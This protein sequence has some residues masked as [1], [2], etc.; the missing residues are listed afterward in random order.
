MKKL[1]FNLLFLPTIF[2]FSLNL[3][4]QFVQAKSG[5]FIVTEQNKTYTLLHIHSMTANEILLEE[6]SIPTHLVTHQDWKAWMKK[7][8]LGHT[9]WILYAF[10]LSK[11]K[12]TEC[13]SFTRRAHLSPNNINLFLN[14]LLELNLVFLPDKER[15]QT[16]P[17]AFPGNVGSSKPWGP[18]MIRDGQKVKEASYN[19]YTT[20][21]PQDQ[22][23]LSGKKIV[24]YFD[25]DHK[26]FPFPY[27]IQA[28]EGG[29]KYKIRAVDSGR[30]LRSPNKSL[31]R[32]IPSF[33]GSMIK[34]ENKVYFT[35]NAPV[36]YH[37]L[38]LYAIDLSN[39]PHLTLFVPSVMNR[40]N[41]RVILEVEQLQLEQTLI[42]GHQY[43]WIVVSEEYDTY[44]EMKDSIIFQR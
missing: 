30:D 3:K 21:W 34:E 40:Q 18:P 11:N 22:S 4:D 20:T 32:R 1:L 44:A 23:E 16:G 33:I 10:D 7:G 28:R 13:Y 15:L 19:V 35:L 29:M 2:C 27:W 17:N 24:L 31:P 25:K 26:E 8:A 6:V 38:K 41:D 39:D 36:Y 12:I 37:S 9:S 43:M 14:T 5:T 42:S